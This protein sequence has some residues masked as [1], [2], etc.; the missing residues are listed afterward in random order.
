MEINKSFTAKVSSLIDNLDEYGLIEGERE[1]SGGV[2]P[3]SYEYSDG[4]ATL[5]YDEE[6]EGSR[7]KTRIVARKGGVTVERS[8]DVTSLM[9]FAEGRSHESLYK[10]GPY[11]FDVTVRARRVRVELSLEKARIDLIYYMKIGGADKSVRMK[12]WI[13]PSSKQD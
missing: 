3:A 4:A 2:Y 8:G 11:S 1:E 7:V 13:L 6:N 9:E 12:I 10:A 5:I